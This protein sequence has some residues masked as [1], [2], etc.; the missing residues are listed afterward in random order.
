MDTIVSDDDNTMGAY[1]QYAVESGKLPDN[2]PNSQLFANPSYRI[3]VMISLI[4]LNH[5]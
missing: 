1:I 4:Q 3:K 2:I 5:K